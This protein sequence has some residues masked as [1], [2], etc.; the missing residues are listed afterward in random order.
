MP[1]MHWRR[2]WRCSAER[3]STSERGTLFFTLDI[4]EIGGLS[5]LLL[6]QPLDTDT[7][8]DAVSGMDDV[9]ADVAG[10]AAD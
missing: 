7:G 5:L 1:Q 2:H 6:Q 9:D 8:H 3:G 4:A 10:Y